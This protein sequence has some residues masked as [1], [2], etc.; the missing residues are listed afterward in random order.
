MFQDKWVHT[1]D[2]LLDSL[3]L[4]YGPTGLQTRFIIKACLAAAERGVFMELGSFDELLE[5]NRINQDSWRPL[6]TTL[7]A[8]PGGASDDSG[9]ILFGRDGK[10]DVVATQGF[11]PSSSAFLN[12]IPQ[13]AVHDVIDPG[14]HDT[15]GFGAWG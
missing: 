14:I 12:H 7:R 5:V 6:T 9:V 8:D 10:G 3:H 13:D 4:Q 2:N 1:I 11:G 15:F